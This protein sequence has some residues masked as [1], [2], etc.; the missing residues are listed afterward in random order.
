MGNFEGL[1]VHRLISDQVAMPLNIFHLAS[2]K[3]LD[4]SS[5]AWDW[6][7]YLLITDDKDELHSFC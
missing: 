2:A 6:Y 3:G 7:L 4:L 1:L 5:H